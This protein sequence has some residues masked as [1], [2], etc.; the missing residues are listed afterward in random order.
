MRGTQHVGKRALKR[1]EKL[2]ERTQGD[3]LWIKDV[4]SEPRSSVVRRAK[5]YSSRKNL[6]GWGNT[7]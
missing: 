1:K 6:F 5:D 3:K 4:Y 2:L 7:S